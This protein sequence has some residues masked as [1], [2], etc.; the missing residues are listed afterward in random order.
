MM[1]FLNAPNPDH[2][3]F[4]LT[5]AAATAGILVHQMVEVT[6]TAPF[7]FKVFWLIVA[8]SELAKRWPDHDDELTVDDVAPASRAAARGLVPALVAAPPAALPA[9][10][11][12]TSL[13]LTIDS[14]AM[15]DVVL[16]LD[17]G[18]TGSTALVFSA[19]RR[20]ARPGLRRDHP[21]L[22]AARL[23][24]ARSG[25]DLAGQPGG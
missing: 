25:R 17:Q 5:M 14:A 4:G 8:L 15:S 16:A 6:L 10:P 7:T 24:R 1:V 20:G 12:R 2:K 22:S 18:T 21:A 9:Q 23:G 13:R 11:G 3:V 19:S